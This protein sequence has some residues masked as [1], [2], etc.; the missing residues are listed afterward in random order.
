MAIMTELEEI[1]HLIREFRDARDWMQFH[2]PKN[3]ACSISIEANELL[4]HFQWK[5]P[6]E[7][8]VVTGEKKV[9][10]AHEVADVAVYLIELADN[11]GIDLVQAIREKL[12]H[13]AAKYPVSRS[14]GS[15]A[16]YTEL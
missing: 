3:L 11:L 10:I 6:E 4:E 14:K 12:A 15:A 9:Q 13:N 7:S 8:L 1:R 16:K 5:T 2:N